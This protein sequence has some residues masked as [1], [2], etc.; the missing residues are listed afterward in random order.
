MHTDIR[1]LHLLLFWVVTL[2]LPAQNRLTLSAQTA[3]THGKTETESIICT[4]MPGQE[5]LPVTNIN[6]V[7]QDSKGYI[8]YG[9][10]GGG[11]CRYNGYDMDIFRSD[12]DHPELLESNDITC[13]AEDKYKNIWIGTRSGA[14]ILDRKNDSIRTLQEKGVIH[15]KIKSITTGGD[16]CI[17]V[18]AEE[19]IF[20]YSPEGVFTNQYV[21]TRYDEQ[22]HKDLP[23]LVLN[24]CRDAGGNIWAMQ[25]KGGLLRMDIHNPTAGFVTQK[26]N[27]TSFPSYLI[28]DTLSACYWVATRNHGIVKYTPDSGVVC[29][30]NRNGMSSCKIEN[31]LLDPKHNILWGTSTDHLYAYKIRHGKPERI[32]TLSFL[33]SNNNSFSNMIFDK[34]GQLWVASHTSPSFILSFDNEKPKRETIR[35]PQGVAEQHVIVNRVVCEGDYYWIY[36]DKNRLSLYERHSGKMTFVTEKAIPSPLTTN[37]SLE[38]CRTD[39]G[40]W[41]CYGH[42]LLRMWHEG[43]DVFWHEPEH[44]RLKSYITALHDNGKGQLVIGTAK[45]VYLYDYEK[46]TVKHLT[47]TEGAVTD[48]D[49]TDDGTVYFTSENTEL[50]MITPQG[51]VK[52]IGHEKNVSSVCV[53]RNGRIWLSTTG[54]VYTYSGRTSTLCEVPMASNTNGDAIKQLDV[55]SEGHIW[56]L[57]DRLLKEYNPQSASFRIIR[58]K[59]RHV[60]MGVFGSM[61]IIRDSIYIGGPDALC[62][63]THSDNMDADRNIP[64]PVITS[65]CINGKKQRIF[66]SVP[67]LQITSESSVIEIKL[68]TF[69]FLHSGTIRFAYR[70]S[71]KQ[72]KW[73][74][75]PEGQNTL[76]IENL[77]SGEYRLEVKATNRYGVWGPPQTLLHIT[78]RRAW[79]RRAVCL[80][81]LCLLAGSV[82]G[83]YLKNK[84]KPM[85]GHTPNG[86]EPP[87]NKQ[88]SAP[89]ADKTEL[90]ETDRSFLEKATEVILRNI[91]NTDYSV[92]QFS[93]DM[94]MSRMNL[95]RKLQSLTGQSPTLFIRNI[96]LKRAAHLLDTSGYSVTEVSDM[97]GFS[98]PKY[99]SRCFKELYGVLP[100][101][102]KHHSSSTP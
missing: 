58:N 53:G 36:Q 97:V 50:Q 55:D 69:D 1:Q 44:V 54:N 43:M 18:C 29:S 99:F 33:P 60:N 6:I 95:Y 92:E 38:P 23:V 37:R 102:Y 85:K 86:A 76:H 13:M 57:S 25:R 56:I 68:S 88:M 66:P 41:T 89:D 34:E 4:E 74:Y 64:S 91:D 71:D 14:Y 19:N 22:T 81:A 52:K 84:Y 35:T 20:R 21:S 12:K 42:R 27:T 65:L 45:A 5:L 77:P 73:T 49:M 83:L 7:F 94:C 67:P 90:N 82:I 62:I 9:T 11:I 70:L 46:R 80:S 79:N 78:G 98:S 26:W 39:R 31:L 28:E 47:D 75:I 100:T 40:I 15:E 17:W 3:E 63:F 59:E 48:I 72:E 10:D 16:N 93:S 96:R 87:E 2:I 30:E 24:L 32:N 101:Q 8:W 51:A 61:S